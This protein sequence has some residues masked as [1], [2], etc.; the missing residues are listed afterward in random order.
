MYNRARMT[1]T[2]T[3]TGALSLGVAVAG[4]QT[5]SSAG[6]QNSDTVS[7]TIED[8]VNWEIGTGTF[9]SVA[10]T[11]SRTV[12]QS[13]D[14]TT[15]GTAAISVTT[16]AQVYITAL[17]ADIVVSGGALGTPSS[18][19]LTNATGLPLAT[20]VT[21]TL[22]VAN[23]GTG[24]TSFG[25]GVATALGNAVNGASGLC[26]QDASGN[27]GLGVTPSAWGAFTVLQNK[28]FSLLGYDYGQGLLV[29]NGYYDGSVWKAI[30]TGASTQYKQ[31]VGQHIWYT[32]ASVS[33]GNP[34]SF[35]QAMT[36]DASGRLGIGAT[37]PSVPLVVGT[38]YA[39]FQASLVN[40]NGI[41]AAQFNQ[42]GMV[43]IAA[44]NATAANVGGSLSFSAFDGNIS[45]P[46]SCATISG[47]RE[48]GTAGNYSGYFAVA[49]TTS[50]GTI[51]ERMRVDSAGNVGIGTATPSSYGKFAVR[52]YV[53]GGGWNYSTS[54]SDAVYSTFSIGHASGLTLLNTD[55]AMVFAAA[56]VER[57]RIDASGNLLVG[58]TS[59]GG[60]Y[61]GRFV[62]STGS[63][64]N[65]ILVKDTQANGAIASFV[66]S[67]NALAGAI[68]ISG[69][70]TTYGTSS[71]IKLKENII[72]AAPALSSI[73][74]MPIRQFDWKADGSHTD[75]GVVAQEANEYAPE[76][77]A[78][79]DVWQ[80]DYG[81]ITPR[82]IKAFQELAAKVTALEEQLNG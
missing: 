39:S 25:T 65:G 16:S 32:G 33:A 1:V 24:I 45:A 37:S 15:Y 64:L 49:T 11:L 55:A 8:G 75:Y 20:G 51:D 44:T 41:G 7:Y 74:S 81:R 30:S 31:F 52:G 67:S 3:G 58:T 57:M 46:Y 28:N 43:S 4:Y 13:F 14:G 38:N 73:I 21:G 27:L 63:G 79:R 60:S 56:S 69:I 10:G 54:F 34:I 17:A 35:T 48:S 68:T 70:T 71:D 40:F 61:N 9:N 19:T 62:T 78:Q 47:R 18:A 80:V 2:S 36:L 53:A 72:D 6:A 22:P 82:L 29:L 42:A 66:N 26:V 59:Q 23:G 50:N 5:F 77:V 12:T 76:M